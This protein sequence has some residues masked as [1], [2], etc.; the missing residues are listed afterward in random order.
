MS[1][2]RTLMSLA[3]TA[4][5]DLPVVPTGALAEARVLQLENHAR[6]LRA[7]S[8][9][10]LKAWHSVGV[11]GRRTWSPKRQRQVLRVTR[12]AT[13]AVIEANK[14]RRALETSEVL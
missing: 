13:T 14:A 3:T 1:L 5:A 12:A 11:C 9:R 10:R 8:D 2:F 6:K 4:G 7:R